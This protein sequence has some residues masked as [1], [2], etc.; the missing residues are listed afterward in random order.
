MSCAASPCL[1]SSSATS[2]SSQAREPWLVPK[3][4]LE[5]QVGLLMSYLVTGKFLALFALMFGLSLLRVAWR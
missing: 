5:R 1:V 4:V 2:P 3:S